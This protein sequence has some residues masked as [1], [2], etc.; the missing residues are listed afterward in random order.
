MASIIHTNA[1]SFDAIV[2][3]YAQMSGAELSPRAHHTLI[4]D[5]IRTNVGNGYNGETG[6]F[7]APKEGIFV[8][9]WV[10]RL[11]S[12]A[13][14]TELMLNNDVLGVIFLRARQDDDSSVSGL[15]VAHVA[16]GDVVFVRVHSLLAGDGNIFSNTYGNP[17]FS[18][19]LLH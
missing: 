6:I 17:S 8:L 1:P 14:S 5:K 13:H 9:N 4:F 3:F 2:A 7:T 16:K 15:A 19:W 18:G 10:I 12:A 11:V